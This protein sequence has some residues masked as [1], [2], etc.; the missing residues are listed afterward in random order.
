MSKI[1]GKIPVIKATLLAWED[2]CEQ[3]RINGQKEVIHMHQFVSRVRAYVNGGNPEI[4][5]RPL[6]S[7]IDR[8]L[9]ELRADSQINYEYRDEVYYKLEIK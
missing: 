7:N 5:Y 3:C 2:S 9:R 1:K 4:N 8:R 6:D